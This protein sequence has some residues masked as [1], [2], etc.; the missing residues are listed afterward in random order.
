[1][2]EWVVYY[3]D[4]TSF[5]WRDGV[6]HEA[7]RR[8]VLIVANLDKEVGRVLHHRADFYIWRHDQWLPSDKFGLMDYLLEPGFEKIVLWG[9]M[10]TRDR[11]QKVYLQAFH[12]ARLPAKTGLQDGEWG[13]P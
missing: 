11:M 3:E 10:T 12:D 6:A 9:R 7:P 13:E 5:S 2:S 1:M 8:G 4:G